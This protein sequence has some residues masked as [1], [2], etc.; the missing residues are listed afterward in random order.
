MTT[1]LATAQIT[2]GE[3]TT[4]FLEQCGV[5]AAFGVISIHN[6]PI[7]D[8]F[9]RRQKIRF[10]SARGE[11]GACNM[12]DAYARVTGTLGVCVTSTGTGAGNA[13]YQAL[14][15]FVVTVCCESVNFHNQGVIVEDMRHAIFSNEHLAVRN[16]ECQVKQVLVWPS[17]ARPIAANVCVQVQVAQLDA[18]PE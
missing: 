6:M 13:R 7:L 16:T 2:V 3:L 12:A 5:K 10:V 17:L 4:R 18:S 8:A 15:R 14:L 11:A 9:H 1:P